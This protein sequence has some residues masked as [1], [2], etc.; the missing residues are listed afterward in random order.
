MVANL[1]TDR[2]DLEGSAGK[3]FKQRLV[4]VEQTKQQVLGSDLGSAHFAG[5]KTGEVD[6]TLRFLRVELKHGAASRSKP[7]QE[8][9]GLP[10]PATL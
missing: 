3:P 1:L 8:P 6:H 7:W 5:L 10:P 9:S 2:L 4:L